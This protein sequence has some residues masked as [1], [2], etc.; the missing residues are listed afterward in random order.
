MH[1]LDEGREPG[2]RNYLV[3]SPTILL[4]VNKE[5]QIIDICFPPH[6]QVSFDGRG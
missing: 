1:I 4:T 2:F 5:A 3:S 6:L